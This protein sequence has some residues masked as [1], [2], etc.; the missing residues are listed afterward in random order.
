MIARVNRFSTETIHFLTY[1]TDIDIFLSQHSVR[2][3]LN[4][5]YRINQCFSESYCLPVSIPADQWR[6]AMG[7]LSA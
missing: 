1:L 3:A 4:P 6:A 2:C 5:A 7:L